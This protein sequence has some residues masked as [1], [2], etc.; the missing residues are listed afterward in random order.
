MNTFTYEYPV[1]QYFGEKT[2]AYPHGHCGDSLRYRIGTE[3]RSSDH[4]SVK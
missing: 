1:K 2:A 4:D 3:Q